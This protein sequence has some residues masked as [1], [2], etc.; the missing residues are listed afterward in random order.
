MHVAICVCNEFNR[1]KGKV[2]YCR[3]NWF[4]NSFFLL[5]KKKSFILLFISSHRYT[6]L[7][8]N[9]VCAL[10]LL[11]ICCMSWDVLRC[12]A[13]RFHISNISKCV[14]FHI[15]FFPSFD[16]F[17]TTFFRRVFSFLFFCRWEGLYFMPLVSWHCC[18]TIALV[19]WL[20]FS[21]H[22]AILLF[23]IATIYVLYILI[24]CSCSVVRI[25][26]GFYILFFLSFYLLF[27]SV[28]IFP[29]L[30][31]VFFSLYSIPSTLQT[32][33]VFFGAWSIFLY[34]H[35]LSLLFELLF[36]VFFLCSLYAIS[37]YIF[38]VFFFCAFR[39][40]TCSTYNFLPHLFVNFHV[41]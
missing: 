11:A 27:F 6:R 34:F 32:Y 12:Y 4:C 37:L 30:N 20:L 25:Q 15:I 31:S 36:S 5:A 13:F 23:A 18:H 8:L 28:Y 3:W 39:I 19:S 33:A 35:S 38:S 10:K 16:F 29:S 41:E 40:S 1:K 2:W 22:I 21:I 26:F 24:R 7:L 9:D 14:F 17:L